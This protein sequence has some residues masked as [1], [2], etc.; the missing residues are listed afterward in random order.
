M[1][2]FSIGN[3]EIGN[4]KPTYIVLEA[5]NCHEG[6]FEVAKKMVAEAVGSGVDAIKF[7]RHIVEDEMI[8]AHPSL[9]RR[10]SDH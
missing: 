2:T 5:A 4:G 6:N 9:V 8:S 10:I 3:R 1:N 7:Q